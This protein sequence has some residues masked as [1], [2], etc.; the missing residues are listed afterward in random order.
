MKILFGT[1]VFF[2]T[3]FFL[4]GCYTDKE[5]LLYGDVICD[6][7]DV[8]FNNDIL[9]IIKTKCATSGCHVQGGS[10]SGIFENYNQIKAKADN[11]SLARRVL[12]LK[13]MPP[14]APLTACQI[15]YFR[16]WLTDGAVNN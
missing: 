7:V 12:E 14:T 3:S 2:L 8:S 6:T 4:T 13:D 10:G 15:E 11:Q 16:Q 1:I 9:P 5:D